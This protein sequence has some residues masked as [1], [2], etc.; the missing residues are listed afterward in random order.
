MVH[1]KHWQSQKNIFQQEK[2]EKGVAL[3]LMILR[4]EPW[5]EN[6]TQG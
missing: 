4:Q 1:F 6:L 2:F 5:S 3:I